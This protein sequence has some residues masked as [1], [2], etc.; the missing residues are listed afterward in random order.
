M[1]EETGKH[2]GVGQQRGGTAEA[3]DFGGSIGASLKA[4]YRSL[5]Q[6]PVPELFLN[7]LEKLDQAE[8]AAE[9]SSKGRG[10]L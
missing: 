1:D 8:A 7:L 9:G 3:L 4:L 10:P 6:E 2:G 5:E